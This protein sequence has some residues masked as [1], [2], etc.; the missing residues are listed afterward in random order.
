VTSGA[1]D[2]YVTTYNTTSDDFLSRLPQR[3]D[4]ALWSV[5]DINS[6]NHAEA[7][8]SVLIL[9]KDRSYC[10]DCYYVIAV[11][12]HE[13]PAVYTVTVRTLEAELGLEQTHLM[14]LGVTQMV[15]LVKQ[16]ANETGYQRYQFML[17]SKE[18]ATVVPTVVS[19][20]VKL[21][22]SFGSPD[23]AFAVEE[24]LQARP[25]QIVGDRL[26]TE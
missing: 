24:G 12:T 5:M 6:Q 14:R 15:K 10:L 23:D 19:G 26:Q 4:D 13:G 7:D 25:I 3:K 21:M 18:A 9:Q 1:A 16:P 20:R 11:I 8:K 22:V 17:D 2:L